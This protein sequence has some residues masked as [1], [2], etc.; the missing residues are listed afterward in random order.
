MDQS[1]LE[2]DRKLYE[3]QYKKFENRLNYLET[4]N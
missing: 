2:T 4:Q 1:M 3:F